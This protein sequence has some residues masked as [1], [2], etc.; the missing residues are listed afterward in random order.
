MF[1]SWVNWTIFNKDRKGSWLNV[2]FF[3]RG[4]LNSRQYA[5]KSVCPLG[6]IRILVLFLFLKIYN[7]CAVMPNRLPTGHN[8]CFITSIDLLTSSNEKKEPRRKELSGEEKSTSGT[9]VARRR[10]IC[11]DFHTFNQMRKCVAL[12]SGRVVLLYFWGVLNR[13]TS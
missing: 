2:V 1:A 12:F 3:H 8:V 5:R 13:S 4:S 9:T 7:H 11:Y 10:T 6:F